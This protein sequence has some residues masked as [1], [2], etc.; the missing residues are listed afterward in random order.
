MA[1]ECEIPNSLIIVLIALFLLR[2]SFFVKFLHIFRI[3]IKQYNI[4]LINIVQFP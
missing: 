3:K 2:R 1:I 4:K